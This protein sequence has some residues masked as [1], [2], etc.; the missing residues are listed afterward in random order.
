MDYELTKGAAPLAQ[1]VENMSPEDLIKFGQGS[2]GMYEYQYLDYDT[3][4]V[5]DPIVINT[6]Y[7]ALE[8]TAN[9]KGLYL[10]VEQTN[11]GAT[12]ETIACEVTLNGTAYTATLGGAASGG[13]FYLHFDRL[14]AL[15]FNASA[16]QMRSI[17]VDQSAPV[18]SRS[19]QVRVRQTTAVDV[20]SAI[21]EVNMAYSTLQKV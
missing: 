10:I 3:S 14:G 5:V 18:E 11:N 15:Q 13:F 6:W 9:V 4:V 19:M 1:E 12:A 8:T 17:D 16:I 21:I 2:A 7:T 20:V